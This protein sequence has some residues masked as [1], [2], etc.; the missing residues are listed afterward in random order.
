MSDAEI[1]YHYTDQPGWNAIRAQVD[2]LFKASQPP[3]N[4]PFGVY[5]TTLRVDAPKF[6]K[7]TRIP[8]DKQEY[9]FAFTGTEGLEQR[10]EGRRPFVL[11][12]P[13]DYLVAKHRQTYN[14]KSETMP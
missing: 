12:S 10:D 11:L 6:H 1:V 14:G 4:R 3:G 8:V 7:K 5:F 13:T 2:W 9:V